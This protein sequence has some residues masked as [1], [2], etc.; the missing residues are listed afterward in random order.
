MGTIKDFILI[1]LFGY[2]GRCYKCKKRFKR[3]DSV[4]HT[5]HNTKGKFRDYH[6]ECEDGN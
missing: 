2:Y 4:W 5:N 6:I 3:G 1:G